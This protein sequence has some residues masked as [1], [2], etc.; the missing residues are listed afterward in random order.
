MTLREVYLFGCAELADITE[1]ARLDALYLLEYVCEIDRTYYFLHENEEI[2]YNKHQEYEKLIIKR[3]ARVPLQHLTGQQEFMGLSFLVNEDVLIPRQDTEVLVEE[4]EKYLREGMHV[5][6]LC[7]GS[8]CILLSLLKRTPGV[9]G[10]GADISEKALRVAEM[11]AKR[12][13]VPA[14]FIKSDLFSAVAGRYDVI[15]SNPPYI[16]SAEIAGLMEEVKGHEPLLAL[17]GKEDGLFYYRKIIS[18]GRRY[19]VPGG[20]MVLEIGYDQG[21]K[22]YHMFQEEGFKDIA[23]IKD[24]AGNDRVVIAMEG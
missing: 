23:V 11:N 22:V 14:E 15:V 4:A 7:T 20:R 12:H 2:E 3:K 19:L 24:L 17:D 6:D 16:A 8:G 1:D 9:T 5:L 21:D 10:T 18:M 13:Q